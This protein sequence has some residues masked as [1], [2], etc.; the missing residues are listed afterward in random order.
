MADW[1][2]NKVQHAQIGEKI[3]Q[4]DNRQEERLTLLMSPSY[5]ELAMKE[6]ALAKLHVVVQ[7]TKEAKQPSIATANAN[8]MSKTRMVTSPSIALSQKHLADFEKHTTGTGSKLL[9]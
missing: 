7:E 5:Q 1:D 9:K 4:L 2:K 6:E 8:T 3:I